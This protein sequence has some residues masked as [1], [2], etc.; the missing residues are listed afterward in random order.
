[1]KE[2]AEEFKN[3]FNCL[4]ENTEKYITF[5]VTIKKLSE[6][7]KTVT[8]KLRFIHSLAN[9]TDNLSEINNKVCKKC[10]ERNKIKSECQY[11]KQSKNKY[12]CKTCHDISYKPIKGLI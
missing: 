4:G 2:L 1:M 9:L 8:Y 12:R 3:D 11:I 6:D 10:M 7:N 5:S